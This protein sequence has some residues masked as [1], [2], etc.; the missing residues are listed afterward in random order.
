MLTPPSGHYITEV[1]AETGCLVALD[2]M[3][4]LPIFVLPKLRYSTYYKE[5]NPSLLDPRSV[6]KTVAA[7][8]SLTRASLGETLS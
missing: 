8:C 3:V 2:I 6:E 5:V 1:V 7:G 4:R